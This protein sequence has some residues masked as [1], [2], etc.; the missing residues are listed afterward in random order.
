MET[1]KNLSGQSNVSRYE[2]GRDYINV[3]FKDRGKDGCN[4]YKY[5]YTSAGQ[6]NIE[7]MKLL[8][9]GGSGLLT[10]IVKN[11]KKSYEHKW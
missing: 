9:I 2:I 3:E 7:Q 10:F 5:S 8:A 11:V 4:T 6:S 1:Y